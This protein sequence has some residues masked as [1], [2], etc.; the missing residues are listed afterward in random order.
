VSVHGFNVG[1]MFGIDL[2]LAKVVSIGLD[3]DSQF[4]FLQRP[5]PPL[6]CPA[7]TQSQCQALFNMNATAQ[8]KTLYNNSGSS[9]GFGFTAAAHVGIHF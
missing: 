3:I 9:V 4:L 1:P 2:Y 8:E 6:P 5:K 7:G